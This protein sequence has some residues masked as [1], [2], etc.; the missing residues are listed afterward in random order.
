MA[1]Q[2]VISSQR[3]LD[4]DVVKSKRL[5]MDYTV[6]VV[7]VVIDGNDYRVIV[8]G[9][10]SLAA[11]KLDNVAPVIEVSDYNYQSEIDYMGIDT[12]MLQH[13]IDS[14]WYD[15]STGRGVF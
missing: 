8:D 15:V 7:D 4:D 9:H 6:T 3:Y 11:A 5:S 13:Y 14:D 10:H 1:Q 12:F 2:Q